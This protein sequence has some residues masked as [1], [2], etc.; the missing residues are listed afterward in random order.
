MQILYFIVKSHRFN[1]YFWKSNRKPFSMDHLSGSSNL[2]RGKEE[3]RLTNV[4]RSKD[5]FE[6]NKVNLFP[7]DILECANILIT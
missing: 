4:E 5:P 1:F 2:K 7:I 3:L 6:V